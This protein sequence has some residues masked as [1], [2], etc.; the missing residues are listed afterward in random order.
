MN[1]I[2]AIVFGFV[3]KL[4]VMVCDV[5]ALNGTGIVH[6]IWQMVIYVIM[7]NLVL[8]IFNLIPVPPLDGFQIIGELF[9]LKSTNFYWGLY[10]YG[11][12]ILLGLIIFNITDLIISPCVNAIFGLIY[13]FIIL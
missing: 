9:N 3:A 13:N 8:M 11:S 7:I 10:Q 2:I 12:L 1:L 4:M 5:N 6:I